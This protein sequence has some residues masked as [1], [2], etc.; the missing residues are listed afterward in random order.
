[1]LE[2][3]SRLHYRIRKNSICPFV[4]CIEHPAESESLRTVDVMNIL[5]DMFPNVLCYK[6]SWLDFITHNVNHHITDS[7]KVYFYKDRKFWYSKS[8]VTKEKLIPDFEN[9]IILY[10]TRKYKC[11]YS[12]ISSKRSKVDAERKHQQF[13]RIKTNNTDKRSQNNVFPKS[14]QSEKFGRNILQPSL[15]LPEFDITKYNYY[16]NIKFIPQSTIPY[17]VDKYIFKSPQFYIGNIRNSTL[18]SLPINK[19]K[20]NQLPNF[21]TQTSSI[22]SPV[23]DAPSNLAKQE[24]DINLLQRSAGNSNNYYEQLQNDLT[25]LVPSSSKRLRISSNRIDIRTSQFKKENLNNIQKIKKD[26]FQLTM[27]PKCLKSFKDSDEYKYEDNIYGFKQ[28]KSL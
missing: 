23:L 6:L 20:L 13:L 12:H 8:E 10:D 9:L 26:M 3:I 21:N 1:M 7:H 16:K 5:G 15:Y 22:Y 11:G 25:E 2:K 24:T 28:P 17:F 19:S 14:P 18:N 4:L 27:H